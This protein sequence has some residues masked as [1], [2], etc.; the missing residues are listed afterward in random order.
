LLLG[1][2]AKVKVLFKARRPSQSLGRPFFSLFLEVACPAMAADR[3]PLDR[4]LL[5]S[6]M[7][8]FDH[9]GKPILLAPLLG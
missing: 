5:G 3:L 2:T 7:P 1:Q 6:V 8:R 4:Q 9:L